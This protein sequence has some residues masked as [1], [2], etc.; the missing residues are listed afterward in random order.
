MWRWAVA[1]AVLM[2]VAAW[3]GVCMYVCVYAGG[4]V[5]QDCSDGESAVR[6]I[7]VA[8]RNFPPTSPLYAIIQ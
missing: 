8:L 7:L 3:V 4:C 5:S 1:A 2:G 6:P